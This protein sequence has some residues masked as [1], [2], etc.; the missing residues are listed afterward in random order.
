MGSLVVIVGADTGLKAC[1]GGDKADRVGAWS[2]EDERF[3]GTKTSFSSE[4][5]VGRLM[6]S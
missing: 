6:A 2:N 5:G 3:G 1:K 4:S